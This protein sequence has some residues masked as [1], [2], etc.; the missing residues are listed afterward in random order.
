MTTVGDW[1]GWSPSLV[2]FAVIPSSAL[3]SAVPVRDCSSF[4]VVSSLSDESDDELLAFELIFLLMLSKC[5]LVSVFYV[6]LISN[7]GFR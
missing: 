6:S 1:Y 7:Y 4:S 5:A 3:A 2:T